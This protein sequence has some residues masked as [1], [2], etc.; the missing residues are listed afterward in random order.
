LKDP[1]PM[2]LMTG[3]V[4][5]IQRSIKLGARLIHWVRENNFTGILFSPDNSLYHFQLPGAYVRSDGEKRSS[6]RTVQKIRDA[7]KKRVW[8][9]EFKSLQ[10]VFYMAENPKIWYR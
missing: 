1:A 3:A 5:Q 8:P 10:C 2:E 9:F 7:L 4:L 6:M